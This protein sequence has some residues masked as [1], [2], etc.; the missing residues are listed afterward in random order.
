MRRIVFI[1]IDIGALIILGSQNVFEILIYLRFLVDLKDV[2]DRKLIHELL[3]IIV[4]QAKWTR[5]VPVV[6]LVQ[7][8]L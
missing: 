4:T 1:E 6:P 5:F 3:S 2:V 7:L 8:C